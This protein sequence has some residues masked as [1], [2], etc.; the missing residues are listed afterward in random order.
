M[1]QHEAERQRCAEIPLRAPR[2]KRRHCSSS[3]SSPHQLQKVSTLVSVYLVVV[4]FLAGH[5]GA[6][7]IGGGLAQSY[8]FCGGVAGSDSSAT[9]H[10]IQPAWSVG[11]KGGLQSPHRQLTSRKLS[12]NVPDATSDEGK[13]KKIPEGGNPQHPTNKSQEYL[14]NITG[15]EEDR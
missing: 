13:V 5:V 3:S 14:F 9:S 15:T 8:T 2:M 1:D 10:I 12:K 7:H 11:S 6:F 4:V